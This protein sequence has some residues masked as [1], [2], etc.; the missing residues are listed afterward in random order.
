MTKSRAAESLSPARNFTI[1]LAD[2][3]RAAA[4]PTAYMRRKREIEDLEE[5][6]LAKAR[7]VVAAAR[8]A[9]VD[10][11][12]KARETLDLRRI[13][14]LIARHNR[15]YP[16]EANLPIDPRTGRLVERG[17]RP[18]VPLAEVTCEAL[19]ASAVEATDASDRQDEERV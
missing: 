7:D 14:D 12:A 3:V 15:Y 5:L 2:K 1:T 6:L 10:P 11:V 16:W 9:G 19:V 8:A 4:G 17:G 13:N 18:W